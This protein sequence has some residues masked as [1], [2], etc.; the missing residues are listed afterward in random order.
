MTFFNTIRLKG[1]E[2]VDAE[3]QAMSQEEK[4]Y[5]LFADNPDREFTPFE[6]WARVLPD[7]PITSVR[8]AITCLTEDGRLEKLTTLKGE[9]YGK[10]NHVWRLARND[11]DG[12]M[13]L[14]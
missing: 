14:F 9:R 3:W 2:L 13:S 12:Q 5:L 1:Q 6:V 7:V 11:N 4:V 8:R 10:P